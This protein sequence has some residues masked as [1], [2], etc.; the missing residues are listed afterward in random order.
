MN[1]TPYP[2][3]LT[4][5]QWERLEPFVPPAKPG[6]RPR[7]VDVREV[8]NAYFY[9]LRAG[10]AWRMLP[11]DF[12]PWRTVYSCVRRWRLDGA[13][14]RLH[15]RL[16]EEVRL[17]EGRPAQPSAAIL[18]SQTVKV[19]D[20]HAGLKGYDG[21]K[22]NQRPQAAPAGGHAGAGPGRAGDAGQHHRLG[23][24]RDAAAGGAAPVAAAA[25]HLGGQ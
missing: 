5:P 8:L 16:R 20:C 10:C 18:D 14:E 15:E 1:R 12:P 4:D 2:T 13:W 22:K 21:G 3:D 17:A 25:A 11:H 9:L 19:A 24:G 6:G 23:R 7:T